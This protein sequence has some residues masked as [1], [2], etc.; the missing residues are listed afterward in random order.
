MMI[1]N[2]KNGRKV[3]LTLQ[4]VGLIMQRA[5]GQPLQMKKHRVSQSLVLPIIQEGPITSTLRVMQL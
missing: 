2:L 3:L 1:L 4:M 5:F